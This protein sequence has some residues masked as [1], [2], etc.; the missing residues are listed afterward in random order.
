[1]KVFF[2]YFINK[3]FRERYVHLKLSFLERYFLSIF[4]KV[5]NGVLSTFKFF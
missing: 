3:S 4:N 5:F 2:F 1:M